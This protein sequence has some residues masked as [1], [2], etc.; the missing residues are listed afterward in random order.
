MPKQPASEGMERAGRL[1]GSRVS[2]VSGLQKFAQGELAKKKKEEEEAKAK[3]KGM[4][5]ASPS[6]ARHPNFRKDTNLPDEK[7][8]KLVGTLDVGEMQG[9]DGKPFR[10]STQIK[11]GDPYDPRWDEHNKRIEEQKR[12]KK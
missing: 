10:I 1:A 6:P 3:K 7:K 9:P 8:G 11:G 5:D 2:G 4:I 12:K